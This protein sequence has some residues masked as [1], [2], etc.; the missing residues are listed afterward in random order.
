MKNIIAIIIFSAVN[1]LFAVIIFITQ[2][3]EYSRLGPSIRVERYNLLM[4]ALTFP[5]IFVIEEC[6]FIN[7]IPCF[8]ANSFFRGII[9]IIFFQGFFKIFK[10]SRSHKSEEQ[11]G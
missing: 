5:C 11:E 10:L 7:P 6:S 8:L 4:D 3:F 2:I 9:M 1:F